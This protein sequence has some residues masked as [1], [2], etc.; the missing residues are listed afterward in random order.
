MDDTEINRQL[1]LAIGY[2]PKDILKLDYGLILVERD[3][4]VI[5]NKK[6]PALFNYMDWNVIGPIAQVY[7]CFQHH[8]SPELWTTPF[9][10]WGYDTPQ[11]AIALSVLNLTGGHHDC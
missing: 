9:L 5:L 4:V 1:A 6:Y 11:K 3:S 10:E 7:D 8:Y 2:K